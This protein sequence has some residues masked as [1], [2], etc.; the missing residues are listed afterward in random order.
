MQSYAFVRRRACGH[1]DFP[2][3]VY[4]RDNPG[5][6]LAGAAFADGEG[7]ADIYPSGQRRLTM[8]SGVCG[9]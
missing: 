6:G 4:M 7:L 3:Y 1:C 8:V 5:R 2:G 9:A